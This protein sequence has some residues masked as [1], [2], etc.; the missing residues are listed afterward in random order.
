VRRWAARAAWLLCPAIAAGQGVP[1]ATLSGRITA[2]GGRPIAG[3]AVI[4]RSANLQGRRRTTTL[5]TGE[6][7]LPFL[8][9]GDYAV[10]FEGAGLAIAERTIALAAAGMGRLDVELE[11]A[12]VVESVTVS[13]DA[14]AG[15]PLETTQVMSNYTKALGDR[16]PIDR[17]L[18]S[19]ALLAPGVTDNGPAGNI[20]SANTRAALMISGAQ[21]FE[22]L[23]LVDGA[24]VNENLRGQPQDLFIE[25]AIEQTTVLSG[26]VSSE[27][28]RFTGGVV[29]V[30]TRSGGNAFHGSFRTSF[31]S[32]AWR[33]LSPIEEE[34]EQDPRIDKID[35]SYE[36]TL[37]GAAW[38]DRLWFFLAGRLQER[39]DSQHIFSPEV[40]ELGDQGALEIPF[41]H[42]T[43][44]SRGEVKLT[45]NLTPSHNLIGT[46]TT[47]RPTETNAQ[48]FTAGDLAALDA[49]NH[50]PHWLV[51]GN[52][53][54][55]LSSRLFVEAQFSQRKFTTD[56]GSPHNDFVGGTLVDVFQRD[57]TLNSPAGYSGDPQRF[58]DTSWYAKVSYLISTESF[59]THD[60]KL[61][62]EWF[63]KYSL[64]NF[65]F[66]GS[67]FILANSGAILRENQAFP[68]FDNSSAED[69]ANQAVLQW[70]RILQ[71]S[72]GD[73]FRTQ[74]IFLNDRVQW[75]GRLTVNLG[76]RFDANDARDA[77]GHSVS[78]SATW[79]PRLAAQ[80]DASG[81][82]KILVN[83]GYAR[84]AAGLH[85]GIVQFFSSAGQ[86]SLFEWWYTGPCVNCD[87][88]APTNALLTVPQALSVVEAWFQTVADQ[89]PTGRTR[90][91][92]LNR[93]IPEN[94]LRPPTATEWTGGVGVA[95]GTRGWARADFL[96]RTYQ[97]LYDDR[98]DLTTGQVQGPNGPLDVEAL[99]NSD[100]LRRRYEAVQTR[101]DYSITT[102]LFAGASY[103][104][105]RLTGNAVG[106][107]GFVSAVWDGVGAYPEYQRESWSY[108]TGYLPGDQRHRA[109][110][111]FGG[112]FPLSVGEIGF[113]ILENYAS[114][115]PYEA[116]GFV[117]FQD[118][119]G[120]DYV[121]NPGYARPPSDGN[122]FFSGRGAY[123]TDAISSTD[124][125]VTLTAH[126]FGSLDVFVQPQVLN[127][128][129]QHGTLAE[130]ATVITDGYEPF[131]P[132][133]RTPVRGVNYELASSFGTPTAYQPPRTFRFSV[134]L[135]F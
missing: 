31:T 11:P 79:S 72:E 91:Q 135:R 114:G 109:R 100:T 45:G 16:L 117:P 3:V 17:T 70:R 128:F 86:P 88:D 64:A 112:S 10:R 34:F 110:V 105:S 30:V 82:G 9:P 96:Y 33:A 119:E 12:P 95:L 49:D 74:S 133:T 46:Y 35:E 40:P 121:E 60:L 53:N 14:Q 126:L 98:I 113:S 68:V 90:I 69:S 56:F 97:D 38:R 92:G 134:G 99:E 129:D 36:A 81:K 71:P 107:D 83:G 77:A 127:L 15:T 104:W 50:V 26:S 5:P 20:G 32:D 25:D 111:W 73:H 43:E 66:S 6:Y 116:V 61:G 106:E 8:P 67:D 19:F 2:A 125:A 130:D 59:G 47:V 1:L 28:G 37:G 118:P 27:Y 75:G 22:S 41:R 123:R 21:S 84:Y 65:H 18:R 102:R 48:Y 80:F 23:Y 87:P 120:N 13:A 24:V 124:L 52:Y 57:F 7:V 122:Y 93:L 101:L 85:E 44:E 132:F 76:L 42:A 4:A 115:L 131:D 78:N 51:A 108:P 62:Y 58:D 55:V 94:G 103:T 89:P 39:N 54:G 29:S 63:E